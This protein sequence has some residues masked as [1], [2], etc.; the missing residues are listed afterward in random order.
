M[1]LR[2]TTSALRLFYLAPGPKKGFTFSKIEKN[3]V[4]FMRQ[5]ELFFQS[6]LDSEVLKP[7]KV[8]GSLVCVCVCVCVCVV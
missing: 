1:S 2:F 7:G 4:I 3:I 8:C 5:F 6:L